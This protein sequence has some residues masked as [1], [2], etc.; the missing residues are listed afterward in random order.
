VASN[1]RCVFDTNATVSALLFE[2]STPA[3]AFDTALE[4]GE[5]LLSQDTLAELHEVLGREK[6][7][8]YVTRE[9]RD[10][11]LAMLVL[12]ATAIDIVDEIKVCRDLDDDKFLELAVSGEANWI[13]SGDEDLLVLHPFRGISIVTPA[14]FLELTRHLSASN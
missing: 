10:Q 13:V 5:L 6:F 3:R 4:S 12:N 9:E 8:R 14:Q 7:D 11:F 2:Q 1:L